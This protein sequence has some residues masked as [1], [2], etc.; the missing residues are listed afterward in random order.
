MKRLK[1]IRPEGPGPGVPKGVKSYSGDSRF[2]VPTSSTKQTSG[3]QLKS[4]GLEPLALT[5]HALGVP[6]GTV[7]IYIH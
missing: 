1:A 2:Q 5:S 4:K 6:A 3:K 7:R